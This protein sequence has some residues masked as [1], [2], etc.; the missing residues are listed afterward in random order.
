MALL[1]RPV[2]EIWLW[3]PSILLKLD[4]Y[5]TNVLYELFQI[6]ALST[7]DFAHVKSYN[8]AE[9]KLATHEDAPKAYD[10]ESG[11]LI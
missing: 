10:V 9:R 5:P 1:L 7:A 2:L 4:N 6:H 11:I 3:C 8:V